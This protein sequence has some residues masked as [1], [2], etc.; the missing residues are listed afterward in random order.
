[1]LTIEKAHG[2][3]F[4]VSP[5]HTWSFRWL[6]TKLQYY[7]EAVHTTLLA[8]LLAWGLS[9]AHLPNFP[10]VAAALSSSGSCSVFGAVPACLLT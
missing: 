8:R 7:L 1:V 9:S 2:R 10:S 4:S 5:R 6:P 3:R